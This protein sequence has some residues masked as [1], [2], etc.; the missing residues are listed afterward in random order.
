MF[1]DCSSSSYRLYFTGGLV[2]GV[3]KGTNKVNNQLTKIHEIVGDA[4]HTS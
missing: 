2:A 3:E 4:Q 1:T